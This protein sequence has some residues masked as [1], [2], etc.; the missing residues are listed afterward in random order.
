M[1]KILNGSELEEAVLWM[2]EA[3]K[4]SMFSPCQRDKRG[5]VIVKNNEIIGEGGNRLPCDIICD[6]KYCEPSCKKTAIHAEMDAIINVRNRELLIGARMY[7]ARA[8][9]G[10]LIDSRKP[11]CL[12]CA[13]YI[14]AFGISEFVL[15]HEE[16]YVLYSARENYE[17]SL[18]YEKSK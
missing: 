17:L 8:E 13:K 5:V 4:V 11:R 2:N 9:K 15:K 1:P 3:V 14:L 12:D 6:S 18:Q 10:V 7:H 16:G